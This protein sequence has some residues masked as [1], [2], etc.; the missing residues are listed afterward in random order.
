MCN[1]NTQYISFRLLTDNCWLEVDEDSPGHMF[2]GA[3]LT[4]ERVEGVITTA[5]GLV[6]GHLSVR[7]DAVLQTVELPAGIANL[8]TGLPTWILIHS[9]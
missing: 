5:D 4:E 7:L 1:A 9:R 2:S 3:G 6:A 8:D